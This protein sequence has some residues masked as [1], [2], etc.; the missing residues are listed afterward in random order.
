MA[1]VKLPIAEI[2]HSLENAAQAAHLLD[3]DISENLRSLIRL[4]ASEAERLAHLYGR[5]KTAVPPPTKTS[6]KTAAAVPPTP[7]FRKPRLVWAH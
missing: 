1:H 2:E 4:A 6:R 3:P 7:R 5:T